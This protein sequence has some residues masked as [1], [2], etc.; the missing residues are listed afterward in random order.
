MSHFKTH[1]VI[2]SDRYI[3]LFFSRCWC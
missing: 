3:K 1:L 2:L